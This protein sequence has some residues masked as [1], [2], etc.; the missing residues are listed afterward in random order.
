VLEYVLTVVLPLEEF[1]TLT[2][3]LPSKFK[4]PASAKSKPLIFLPD[5]ADR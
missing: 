5:E 1:V 2:F 4:N 3:P